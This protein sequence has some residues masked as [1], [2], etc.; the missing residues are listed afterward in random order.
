MV[1]LHLPNVPLFSFNGLLE[2]NGISFSMTEIN[3]FIQMLTLTEHWS[4]FFSFKFFFIIIIL[5]NN[6][7]QFKFA[8]KKK[9]KKRSLVEIEEILF[10][11][12]LCKN[13]TK[14]YLRIASGSAD[15]DKDTKDFV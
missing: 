7:F 11:Y 4:F 8:I 15:I 3:V 5:D 14:K 12:L 1:V 2:N 6:T 9:K 13:I 10:V